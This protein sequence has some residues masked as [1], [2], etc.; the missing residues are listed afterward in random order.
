MLSDAQVDEIVSRTEAGEGLIAILKSMGVDWNAGTIWLR[1]N[2][3]AG[4]RVRAAEK[5]GAKVN[6]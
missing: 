3:Q 1:D 2:A 6:G 5:V 4:P